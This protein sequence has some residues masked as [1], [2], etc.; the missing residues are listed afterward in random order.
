MQALKNLVVLACLVVPLT[1]ATAA[2][3]QQGAPAR[4]G[5][6]DCAK[7][8]KAGRACELHIEPEDIDGGRPVGTGDVIRA[9][10][11]AT[12]RS[13]IRL[14]TDFRDQIVRSAEQ[15]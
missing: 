3:A 13:L 2:S 8:R 15:L 11:W 1:M 14:R 7:A 9:R 6:D 12:H 10:D 4:A 5:D